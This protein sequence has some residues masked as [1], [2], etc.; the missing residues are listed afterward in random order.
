MGHDQSGTLDC[1][2]HFGDGVGL[3]GTG[4][5]QQGLMTVPLSQALDQLLD[6][7]RLVTRGAKL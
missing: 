3:A 1:L 6:G 4:G 5:A 7:L 2:D